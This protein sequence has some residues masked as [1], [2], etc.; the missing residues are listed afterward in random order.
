MSADRPRVL[1]AGSRDWTDPAPIERE[2]RRLPKNTTV[3][4]GAASRKPRGVEVS[5]DMLADRIARRLGLRVEQWPADWNRHGKRA[6]ILR[7][8]AMLDSG[9]D[10][11]IVFHRNDSRGSAHTIRGAQERGIPVAVFTKP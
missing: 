6:G 10:Y 1:V 9:P 7:N 4:H 5:A 11:A 3:V 8:I 2:L